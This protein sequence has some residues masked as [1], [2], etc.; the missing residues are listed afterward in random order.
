MTQLNVITNV[1]TFLGIGGVVKLKDSD[2]ER[3]YCCCS[4]CVYC[5]CYIIMFNIAH[6]FALIVVVHVATSI[7]FT[8]LVARFL[9][10]IVN[11]LK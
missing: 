2:V 1:F 9:G 5:V 8:P 11:N 10:L 4:Y 6:T 3:F 7:T